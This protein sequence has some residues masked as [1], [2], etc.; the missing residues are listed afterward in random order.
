V[1][2][3]SKRVKEE[4]TNF[5][6]G[7]DSA[8]YFYFVIL[9]E[10]DKDA[11]GNVVG[12]GTEKWCCGSTSEISQASSWSSQSFNAHDTFFAGLVSHVVELVFIIILAWKLKTY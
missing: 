3:K 5:D 11:T 7:C 8:V 6:L 10:V 12:N 9:D 4:T 2:Y 1:R